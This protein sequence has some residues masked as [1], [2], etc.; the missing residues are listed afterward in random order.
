MKKPLWTPSEPYK[1]RSS[2]SHYQHYLYENYGYNFSTYTDLYSWSIENIESFWKTILDFFKIKYS[3]S[4]SEVLIAGGDD[5]GFIGTKWFNGISLSYAEHIFLNKDKDKVAIYYHDEEDGYREVTWG[6]LKNKVSAIQQFLR[7][8]GIKK[9]DTVVGILTNNVEAI[10]IFLAVNSIGAIWSCCSP[11]FGDKSIIERFLL[12]EPKLLFIEINYRY[13]GKHYTKSETLCAIEKQINSLTRVVKVNECE[14]ENILSS[15]SAKTLNFER[16]PFDHPIWILYSSGTTGSPKAIVHATGGNLLE[17]F[18]ALSLHQNVQA[19]DKFLWYTTTGWMM[20]NYAL[21]SLL[22][23]ASLCIFNGAISYNGHRNFWNFVRD[24]KVDHLGAGAAYFSTIHQLDISNYFPKVI[25]STGSPLPI[26]T[27]ENLQQKFPETHIISLSGG[28]DVCS[29]F[30]S[31][32]P[33]LPVYAGAIQCR[34]LGSAILALDANGNPVYNEVGEL[35]IKKPLPSMPVFFWNDEGLN[36]YKESYFIQY[37][38]YWTHGDW[39]SIDDE[40]SIVMQGRSDA[41]LNRAGIRIGTAEIYD[42]VQTCIG[43]IDSLVIATEGVY[44]ESQIILF[45]QLETNASLSFI[46]PQLKTYIREQYSARHIPDLFFEVPDIPY[47][48]SGKKLEIPVK[49]IFKGLTIHEVVSK[50]IMRNPE[51]LQPFLRIYNDLF[52]GKIL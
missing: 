51:S 24:I 27:F 48:L 30:L 18:K 7:N 41:T 35:V 50:D 21:S 15:F 36:R 38:G 6:D 1:L 23:D 12:I 26:A 42:A 19:G 49:K 8:E 33:W 11:D 31:G 22:C 32:C 14:W 28:T 10:A 44:A 5:T 13:N 46:V 40:G 43:I 25:G 17:H 29:A 4:Y 34:T 47:T 2:L 39:I 52:D 16:V 45:L 3:G 9:G 37:P 20:W